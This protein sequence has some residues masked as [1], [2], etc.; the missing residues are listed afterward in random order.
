MY[1]KW[2]ADVATTLP[3]LL[4]VLFTGNTWKNNAVFL[5]KKRKTPWRL[6]N[7]L[8]TASV[9]GISYYLGLDIPEICCKSYLRSIAIKPRLCFIQLL[10]HWQNYALNLSVCRTLFQDWLEPF[11][12]LKKINVTNCLVDNLGYVHEYKL[13]FSLF[14][15]DYL[16]VLYF[17]LFYSIMNVCCNGSVSWF[18]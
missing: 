4:R 3:L 1:V 16:E 18:S 2:K 5:Q 13:T 11:L 6:L 14:F 10:P 17:S 15:L 12:L 9:L 7:N 8:I